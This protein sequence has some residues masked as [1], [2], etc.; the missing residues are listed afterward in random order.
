MNKNI[1]TLSFACLFIF[2][3]KEKAEHIIN[4]SDVIHANV[5]KL[6][7]IIIYDIFTPPVASRI[8]AYTSL[9][10]YEAIR[11][12]EPENPSIAEKLNGFGAMPQP[13]KSQVYNYTLAATKALCAVALKVRIFSDTALHRYE[14]SVENEFRSAIPQDVY[15]R[16]IAFGSK[17]AEAILAR[18]SKDLYK[19]T[20][21][22]SKYLGTDING[23]W[24]PTPPDYFD[25]TE[26]Y[27]KLIHPMTLDSASQFRPVAPLPYNSDT[28]STFYKM[29]KEVYDI[30]V[31]LTDSQKTIAKYWDDNP[32]VVEHSGHLMFANKKITPGGHWMG[33][34]QIA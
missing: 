30:N 12:S 5:N 25:G 15:D 21:G 31:Q 22:M 1:L 20:R 28:T 18:A 29:V 33:I 13:D 3:C 11:F 4:D 16:S 19:E 14:D 34:T 10:M 24:Q 26:P 7:E 23:K 32:F 8:Y 17:V 27:F 6:T 2:S 9:A